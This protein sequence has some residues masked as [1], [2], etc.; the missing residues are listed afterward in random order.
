M[1][2]A[3]LGWLAQAAL[4]QGDDDVDMPG[5]PSWHGSAG[6]DGARC[7]VPSSQ[8][9]AKPSDHPSGHSQVPPVHFS[10]L[11]AHD[12]LTAW[13]DSRGP[14]VVSKCRMLSSCHKLA[15]Q[16]LP[17]LYAQAIAYSIISRKVRGGLAQCQHIVGWQTH[18][19]AGQGHLHT[20]SLANEWSGHCTPKLRITACR[21]KLRHLQAFGTRPVTSLRPGSLS[22]WL[23]A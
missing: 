11:Q 5:S 21:R 4:L 6:L 14:C 17:H 20:D 22:D 9:A 1:N 12:A 18:V 19:Q 7:A 23:P 10:E 13:P 3:A 15:W 2:W 8:Q 16:Q